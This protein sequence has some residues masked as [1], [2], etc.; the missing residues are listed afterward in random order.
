MNTQQY[1]LC[2]AEMFPNS[3]FF[4]EKLVNHKTKMF[5]VH[6]EYENVQELLASHV[7]NSQLYSRLKILLAK[8]EYSHAPLGR[9]TQKG[10][11]RGRHA[12]SWEPSSRTFFD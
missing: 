10:R 2:E 11:R 7:P 3:D 8:G 9:H 6:L 5:H 12:K 4:G 1:R